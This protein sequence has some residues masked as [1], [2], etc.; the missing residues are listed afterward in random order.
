MFV[1]LY[2]REGNGTYLA[3]VEPLR[4]AHQAN[5]ASPARRAV[6]RPRLHRDGLHGGFASAAASDAPIHADRLL[7]AGSRTS[8]GW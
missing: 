6:P 2:G 3:L 8:G 1:W 7:P 4:A 5:A